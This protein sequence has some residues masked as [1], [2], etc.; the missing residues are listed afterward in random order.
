MGLETKVIFGRILE[1]YKNF[2]MRYGV[3]L[4]IVTFLWLAKYLTSN[5]ALVSKKKLVKTQ[6]KNNQKYRHSPALCMLAT[7]NSTPGS[8][9]VLVQKKREYDYAPAVNSSLRKSMTSLLETP[10]VYKQA[11]DTS[12]GGRT[13]HSHQHPTPTHPNSISQKSRGITHVNGGIQERICILI[14]KFSYLHVN[15]GTRERICN[16]IK[17]FFHLKM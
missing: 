8:S 7:S 17:I 11:Y 14:K 5:V 13:V 10:V 15:G 12:R 6:K 1:W 4:C 2:L 3:V 16:F 9:V